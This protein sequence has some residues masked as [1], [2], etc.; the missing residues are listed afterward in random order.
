[1]EDSEEQMYFLPEK[2]DSRCE[3]PKHGSR[4]LNFRNPHWAIHVVLIVIYTIF[5]FVMILKF[6]PAISEGRLGKSRT[7]L[8][9]LPAMLIK[10]SS[11]VNSTSRARIQTV[12]FDER[13]ALYRAAGLFG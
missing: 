3:S 9:L 11:T 6:Q 8:H 2:H 12:P 13:L 1:M 5:S 4:K 10:S 7:L